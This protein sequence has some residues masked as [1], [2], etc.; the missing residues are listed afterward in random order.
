MQNIVADY[1]SLSMFF[2]EETENYEYK[3][4]LIKEGVS[5]EDLFVVEE[6][7]KRKV[8]QLLITSQSI[9][10]SARI[11]QTSAS[12]RFTDAYNTNRNII[13]I[14]MMA[15]LAATAFASI[16][17]SSDIIKL[18][19]KL[20]KGTE[21]IGNGNLEHKID[22]ESGD[23]IGQL[24][25]SFNEM[26]EKL[27]E[28]HSNLEAKVEARTAEL[29]EKT[30]E[31]ERTKNTVVRMLESSE[32]Q[33]ILLDEARIK[34]E[35]LLEET[36]KFYEAVEAA[37]DHIIITDVDGAILYANRAAEQITGY[38]RSEMTG[39][40]SSLWGKQMSPEFYKAMW[41]IIKYDK[42]IFH[43]TIQN[44]R[45]SGELYFASIDISP[46]LDARGNP[47]FFVGIER[48]ITREKELD[49]AK[50]EFVSLASHQLRTPLSAIKWTLEIFMQGGK[51]N[52]K[53]KGRLNDL[54]ISNERLIALVNDLLSV[55][56]I[57]AGKL[58]ANIERAN[59]INCVSQSIHM[60][61]PAA[62]HRGQTISLSVAAKSKT[63]HM[64]SILFGVAFNNILKNAI[65][66]APRDSIIT[67]SIVADDKK[68]TIGVSNR[69]TFVP[70]QDRELLFSKFYR[71]G[72]AQ[73][74]KAEGS[75][76]GLFI[77]KAAVEANG[78]T[79]WCDS[80]KEEGTTFYFT[81]PCR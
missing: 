18:L 52:K 74:I 4:K 39:R 64:D 53:Q 33:K 44:K 8:S 57:E 47:K 11:L 73:S 27:K 36:K 62:H 42:K 14:L 79:I 48:D 56:R 15:F 43:G 28:S 45:K 1:L 70:T 13:I 9:I 51:L 81:V 68:Y 5:Q 7:Q 65:A 23:E 26:A 19:R 32:R 17:I 58:V 76:L 30:H 80:N 3:Q 21:I 20:H 31:L 38:A 72:V 50:T 10:S 29:A 22:I 12:S 46:I 2:A 16:K 41:K 78:G 66:Y 25:R 63:T 49:R 59:V 40:R 24:A 69:G 34:D 77:A 54:Y 75:G 67:V 60:L 61:E 71:G 6:L 55:S 35:V 37:A